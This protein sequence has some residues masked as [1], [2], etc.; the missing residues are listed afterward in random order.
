MKPLRVVLAALAAIAVAGT[1]ANAAPGGVHGKPSPSVSASV[2]EA[3]EPSETEAP[4]P[5]ETEAPEPTETESPDAEAKRSDETGKGPDF[6]GCVGLTGLDNAI[7]RHEALLKIHPDNPGLN[8]S[9][10]HLQTN[11]AR[12]SAS[13][14]HGKPGS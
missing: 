11:A 9:L 14:T 10:G 12:H 1:I 3:P 4:E 5:T 8:N 6:S 2:S 13:G 7:C